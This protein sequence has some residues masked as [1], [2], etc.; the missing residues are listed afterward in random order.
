MT[1]SF[2]PADAMCLI[3]NYEVVVQHL[4]VLWRNKHRTDLIKERSKLNKELAAVLE[5]TNVVVRPAW[6]GSLRAKKPITYDR[7]HKVFTA[8]NNLLQQLSG[9]IIPESAIVLV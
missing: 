9:P 2:I 7:T 3:Q 6:I 8:T 4:E 1:E 5:K